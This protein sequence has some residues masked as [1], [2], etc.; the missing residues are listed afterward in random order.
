M[1]R[2]GRGPHTRGLLARRFEPGTLVPRL[3][4]RTRILGR[5][6]S[7][8]P[9]V[10]WV[11]A[12]AVA[13]GVV[14]TP[15]A[16]QPTAARNAIVFIGDGVDDHQLTIARNY[17]FGARG[18]FSFEAFPYRAA[19][20]VLTVQEADPRIPEYVGDSASG[21]TAIAA[22]VVTSRGRIATQAGHGRPVATLLE[23]AATAGKW[24]GIVTTSSVT[25]ATP[26]SFVA[27]INR[28]YCQGPRDMRPTATDPRCPEA[29][30]SNGGPGSI[31]E[32]IA[33]S[34]VDLLL[35]G[36]YRH[37]DQPDE[38]GVSVLK[39]ARDAGYR[40][41]RDAAGL[42][43][44]V[45]QP[46][47]LLGLFGDDTLPVEWV[48]E[49]DGRARSVAFEADGSVVDPEPYGCVENPQFGTRPTLE[50]MTTFALNRLEMAQ[51]GFLLMVESASIDK[52]AHQGR[53]CGQIGETRALD[54][55]VQVAEAFRARHADTLILVASDHGHAAQ[56]IPW[57]SLFASRPEP[58]YP[59]GKVARVRTLE[60]GVMT[61]SY[62]TNAT[63]L[64]EHT[65]THVP[66]FATGPGAAAVHGLIQQSDL[67]GIVQR[68]LGLD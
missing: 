1:S 15:S 19:A 36:G 51:D 20:R 7:A 34:R 23:L 38:S 17:L 2:I 35:G 28:R 21:G 16:S 46:G 6:R 49:G 37:F 4:G 62:G 24:T 59:P 45:A 5:M 10:P 31:A 48:G 53:P 14:T 56:I 39:R 30:K 57:P 29:S 65:G 40:I 27:H 43:A 41:V 52:Q 32:Q 67:F 61:V 33:A 64:E 22:G 25:D 13:V 60:G 8:R 63:Y 12:G 50:A 66:V 11:L 68:A 42:R 9:V 18:G 55:A 26:A 44:A 3:A 58:Q 54:E 47:K